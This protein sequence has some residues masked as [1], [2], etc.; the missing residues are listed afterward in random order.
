MKA[1]KR[2]PALQPFARDHGIGLVCAQGLHKA[3]RETGD[4]RV[5]LADQIRSVCFDVISTSL[6]DENRVLSRAVV[7]TGLGHIF[8]QH[9]DRVRELIKQLNKAD[10]LVDPGL[11]LIARIADALDD[12]VRWEE[13]SLFP[14]IENKLTDGEL[15]QLAEISSSIEEH[16]HRPTQQ[17]HASIALDKTL[18]HVEACSCCMVQGKNVDGEETT[19]E[20]AADYDS[21]GDCCGD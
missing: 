12:Y 14:A 1:T 15:K 6:E 16:R 5:R 3:V 21:R 8:Q 2:H 9:H 10:P 11:G 19:S 4:D 13:N 18:G 20:A 17:R 7:N